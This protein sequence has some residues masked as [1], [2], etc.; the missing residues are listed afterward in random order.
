LPK[1]FL[2]VPG[3]L[4]GVRPI[5]VDREQATA[6]NAQAPSPDYSAPGWMN[7]NT[8]Q[9]EQ[10]VKYNKEA[11][12]LHEAVPGHVFQ[13]T[14]AQGLAEIPEFRKFYSNSAYVEGWGLYAES[15]G[16]PLGVYADPASQFGQLASERFRA[17]R[18]VVDT[19][20]HALGWTREQAMAYFKEHAPDQSIAEVDRYISW[21]GQALSY[22][23]GQLRIMQLRREGEQ[24]LGTR[25]DIREFHDRILRNG[26]LP[27]ELLQH[28]VE[29]SLN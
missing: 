7:L 16:A 21:P 11:L 25:F 8:Y 6:T 4:Y 28:E 5:P 18:L 29:A 19:G 27:L 23:M 13:L 20:L 17:V 2:H 26:V 15:L 1:Q 22:K 10:Q 14:L 3:L 12:V 24:K 9:P